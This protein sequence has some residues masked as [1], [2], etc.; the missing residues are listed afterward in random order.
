[1]NELTKTFLFCVVASALV[2]AAVMVD[3]GA[4]TPKIFKDQGLPFYPGLT[5]PQA[6]KVIEVIDY[7]EATATARPLKVEFKNKKWTIPSHHGYPAD[8]EERLAKT[9][10]ALMKLR[11]DTIVSDRIED[12]AKYGVI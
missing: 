7:D 8:A 12:H 2:A 1:M 6:P 9:T 11:K 3:P 4:V 10:A 5:D